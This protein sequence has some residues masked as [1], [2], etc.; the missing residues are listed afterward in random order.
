MKAPLRLETS[1]RERDFGEL[2]MTDA[3]N[4]QKIWS[5]DAQ[6]P[7]HTEFSCESVTS[8]LSRTS[9]LI[10]RLE[11]EYKHEERLILLVAH[12]DTLQITRTAFAGIAP[13]CHRSLDHLGNCDVRELIR[14]TKYYS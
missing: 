1:L 2:N 10:Q 9:A 12:G 14:P 11:E 5:C 6:D 3:T 4:Y 7:N 13:E 8:V